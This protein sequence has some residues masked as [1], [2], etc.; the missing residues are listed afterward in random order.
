M[1]IPE[2]ID[3]V[4][5]NK[6][7]GVCVNQKF[8]M[9]RI[10]TEP[11]FLKSDEKTG[12]F[13][14]HKDWERCL[15]TGKFLFLNK[16]KIATQKKVISF[17]LSKIGSNILSGKSITSISLPID[18]FEPR[19]NLER[20]AYSC[21]FAPIY[22]KRAAE[23]TDP[24]EQMKNCAVYL[25]TTTIMYLDLEKPFNPILGETYQGRLDGYPF[26]CE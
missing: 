23:L 12:H 18:I 6:H 19:S 11:Q 20:F 14:F 8:N 25:I 15:K 26:Y 7:W 10:E 24:L 2:I 13:Q 3:F 4:N 9:G 22:L 17:L 21:C 1:S 5:K 16:E